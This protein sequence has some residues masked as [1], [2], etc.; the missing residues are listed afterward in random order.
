MWKLHSHKTDPIFCRQVSQKVQKISNCVLRIGNKFNNKS[1][2]EIA[3]D[4]YFRSY[5]TLFLQ[6]HGLSLDCYL[7]LRLVNVLNSVLIVTL[8]SQKTQIH[9]HNFWERGGGIA[10]KSNCANFDDTRL[11]FENGC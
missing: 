4:C 10:T 2:D 6:V 1:R 9:T 8:S 5:Y 11:K 3:R 7:I